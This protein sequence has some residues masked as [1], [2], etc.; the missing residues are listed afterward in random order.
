[1]RNI[2]LVTAV[3]AS[4]TATTPAQPKT[5]LK[6]LMIDMMHLLDTTRFLQR[7][8]ER[9]NDEQEQTQIYKLH[10]TGGERHTNYYTLNF[11]YLVIIGYYLLL[12]YYLHQHYYKDNNTTTSTTNGQ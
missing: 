1:M 9:E 6:P 4:R 8:W 2:P 12:N 7:E 3:V 5:K 10:T 11:D